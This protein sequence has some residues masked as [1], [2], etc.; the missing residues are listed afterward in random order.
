MV[1]SP[2]HEAVFPYDDRH[3]ELRHEAHT[4]IE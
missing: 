2:E 1:V 4:R 3:V